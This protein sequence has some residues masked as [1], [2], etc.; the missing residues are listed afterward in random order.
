[1]KIALVHDHLCGKG[2]SERVFQAICEAFP[3]ADVYTLAYHPQKTYPYFSQRPLTTTPLNR[4]VRSSEMFRWMF[5]LATYAMERINLSGYDLVISSSATCAKYLKTTAF[6]VC[7]CYIP[8]RALWHFDAYF[9]KSFKKQIL[10]PFLPFLRKRDLSAAGRVD[11]FIAISKSSQ[12][13]IHQYYGRKAEVVYSPIDAQKF[14][15]A[16]EQKAYYLIVSRLEKW[17]K[18]DYAI[19]AFN[20]MGLPL[21]IIGSGAEEKSL[22]AKAFPNISFLGEVD[23]ATLIRA[24]GECKAVI[25]TPFLEYGLIP[26]EANACG[27]AVIGYGKGGIE[28]TMIDQKTAVFFPEQTAESLIEAVRRFESMT[29]QPSA[30]RQHALKW[31]IPIFQQT[32]KETVLA[33]YND[34]KQRPKADTKKPA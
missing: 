7:Y 1:M 26:L 14:T 32:F 27:K 22:K 19:D 3:E 13:Y 28:E 17:K 24:Y 33:L 31:D 21:K 20:H 8:T 25:F 2:G 16:S 6:H 4:V 9:G 29:F 18:V 12:E 34:D 23:D 11:Q 10:K 15:L 5:P 30:L